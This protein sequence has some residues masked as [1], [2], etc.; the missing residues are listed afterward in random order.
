MPI[1]T[2]SDFQAKTMRASLLRFQ[3]TSFGEFSASNYPLTGTYGMKAGLA[4]TAANVWSDASVGALNNGFSVHQTA[5]NYISG[6]YFDMGPSS[7]SPSDQASKGTGNFSVW[8]FLA[9]ES[10]KAMNATGTFSFTAQSV[11]RYTTGEGVTLFYYCTTSTTTT[12]SV[13]FTYTNQ[14]GTSGRVSKTNG[15]L[16]GSTINKMTIVPMGLADGDTGVRSVESITVVS[17]SASAG[18]A[19]YVLAKQIT[20]WINSAIGTSNYQV[21][22]DTAIASNHGVHPFEKNACLIGMMGRTEAS[23]QYF[24]CTLQI[25][26]D[27]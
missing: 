5:Q 14:D 1:T 24:Q 9:S 7:Y 8:D 6:V 19:G 12:P 10:G 2:Y 23:I 16:T 13:Y 15:Y 3:N 18:S 22:M 25:I 27:G 26:N 20:P 17:A 4:P 21:S 11:P